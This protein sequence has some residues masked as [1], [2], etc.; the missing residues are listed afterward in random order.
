MDFL[1]WLVMDATTDDWESIIQIRGWVAQWLKE[2]PELEIATIIK[3][4][5]EEGLFKIMN[6]REFKPNDL[7]RQPIEFWFK[8]TEAGWRVWE[9]EAPKYR[10]S[11][12]QDD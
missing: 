7:L 8:L 1:T 10:N 2:Y 9:A 6:G 3:R 4:L 5:T 12:I 11:K